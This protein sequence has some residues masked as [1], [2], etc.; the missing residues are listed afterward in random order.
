MQVGMFLVSCQ[1]SK[2]VVLKILRK[3]DPLPYCCDAVR[4]RS[5]AAAASERILQVHDG[6]QGEQPGAPSR[7]GSNVTVAT[8]SHIG[9]AVGLDKDG[10]KVR[11]QDGKNRSP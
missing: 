6:Q 10:S 7:Y 1:G 5:V 8:N 3:C 11:V 4:L 9:E 2:S